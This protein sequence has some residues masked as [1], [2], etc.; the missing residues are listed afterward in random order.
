[1]FQEVP[2][3]LKLYWSKE[4]FLLIVQNLKFITILEVKIIQSFQMKILMKITFSTIALVNKLQDT[5]HQDYVRVKVNKST[6]C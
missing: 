2:L 6:I 1:M 3:N 4:R 5:A